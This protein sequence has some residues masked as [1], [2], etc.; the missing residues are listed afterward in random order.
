[1]NTWQTTF[2]TFIAYSIQ[3]MPKRVFKK[4]QI[5]LNAK[6]QIFRIHTPKRG[7]FI[8]SIWINLVKFFKTFLRKFKIF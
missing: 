8:L 7:T 3:K 5:L 6:A 2:F 4:I 1:M